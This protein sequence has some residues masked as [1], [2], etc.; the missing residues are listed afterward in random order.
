LAFGGNGF[1]LPEDSRYRR[2]GAMAAMHR[3]REALR[4]TYP[5]LLLGQQRQLAKGG[6]GGL[7]N[8]LPVNTMVLSNRAAPT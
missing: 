4:T 5:L 3:I 8:I 2:P 6:L 7:S 1:A